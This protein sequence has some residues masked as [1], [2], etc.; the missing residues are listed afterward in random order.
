MK[1][2]NIYITV[3]AL[4][5]VLLSCNESEDLVTEGAIAGGKID[6]SSVSNS[7]V[8]GNTGPYTMEFFINQNSSVQIESIDIYKS[9]TG[10]DLFK[11]SEDE[12]SV[13]A[14]ASNEVKDRTITISNPGNHFITV[15]YMYDEM[16]ADLEAKGAPLPTEDGGLRIGDK[17]SFRIEAHLSDGRTVQQSYSVAYTVST[18]YAGNYKAIEAAYYRIGVLTYVTS[19]WPELTIESVDATTYKMLEYIGPFNGNEWYFQII[20]GVISYPETTPAGAAQVLNDQ[21]L[22]TCESNPGDMTNVPCGGSSNFVVNDD[23]DGKDKLYMS[24]GYYTA[25]SGSREFYQV[26]EKIVN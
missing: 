16:I 7:Y 8:V 9:F 13:V 26:L 10:T 6:V 12:D 14:Y 20:D 18:R 11:D 15:D 2:Y 21:P 5:F 19:D 4:A 3:F 17:F 25:G 23:V 24:V 22:I 1:K